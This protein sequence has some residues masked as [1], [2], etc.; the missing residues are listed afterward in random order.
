MFESGYCNKMMAIVAVA[1]CSFAAAGCCPD[2]TNGCVDLVDNG[3]AAQ[4]GE[5]TGRIAEAEGQELMVELWADEV[6]RLSTRPDDNG[7]YVFGEIQPGQ[8]NLRVVSDEADSQ[9]QVEVRSNQRTVANWTFEEEILGCNG[10]CEPASFRS[11]DAQ[12][13]PL[14]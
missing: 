3:T 8:Y 13:E 12:F 9:T 10:N 11:S 4:P 1:A 5:V 14:N 7:K 2:P 6:S